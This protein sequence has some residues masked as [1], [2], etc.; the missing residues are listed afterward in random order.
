MKRI[1]TLSQI[2][3]MHAFG[4]QRKEKRRFEKRGLFE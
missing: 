2:L 3:I 4:A 1:K